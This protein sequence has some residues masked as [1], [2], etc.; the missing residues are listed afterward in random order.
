MARIMKPDG[1]TIYLNGK[2]ILKQSTKEIA[3]QMAILPQTPSAPGGLTVYELVSYGRF[4]YQKGFGKLTARDRE[5]IDWALEITGTIQFKH[6]SVDALSGGQRQR[7]WIAMALA[8]E[9]ELI[10]LDEPTTYL[11]LAHQLEILEILYSLNRRE[12]RTIVMVIH[13]LNHASRFA[14]YIIAMRNGKILTSGNPNE[15]MTKEHLREVF[16]I[17]AEIVQDP[18]L[19]KPICL[20]YDLI[21]QDE[22]KRIKLGV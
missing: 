14:D 18:R 17:D 9:T 22:Q 10:L 19:N 16:H 2:E 21:N 13:D 5:M 12:H 8:Q 11:D 20:T 6:R 1:G 7:V 15:V 4:P 3:K